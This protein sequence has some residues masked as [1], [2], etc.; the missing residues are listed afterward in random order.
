MVSASANAAGDSLRR[1]SPHQNADPVRG[2]VRPLAS[3]VRRHYHAALHDDTKA[4]LS[5]AEPTRGTIT[6]RWRRLLDSHSNFQ[7]ST[8][9]TSP[10]RRFLMPWRSVCFE[11]SQTGFEGAPL[12]AD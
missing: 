7:S 12:P 3:R 11:R 4:A 9:T 10:I 8:G 6:I 5:P 2:T 1:A